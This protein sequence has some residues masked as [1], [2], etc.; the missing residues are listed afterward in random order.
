MEGEGYD[1]SS[2]F[3]QILNIGIKYLM[4]PTFNKR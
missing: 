3:D 4:N 1:I 2:P